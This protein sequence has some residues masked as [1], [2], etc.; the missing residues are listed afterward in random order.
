MPSAGGS[1]GIGGQDGSQPLETFGQLW[2][3]ATASFAANS[4]L[5]PGVAVDSRMRFVHPGIAETATSA[6]GGASEARF[7]SG[8]HV[9]VA[10]A[11]LGRWK[12]I[13]L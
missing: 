4:T 12:A 1:A 5:R 3:A 7:P 2:A 10:L 8:L 6:P 13:H 9:L 11:V